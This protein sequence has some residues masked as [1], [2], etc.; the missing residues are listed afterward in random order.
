ML[1]LVASLLDSRHLKDRT[2]TRDL[3]MELVNKFLIEVFML[4]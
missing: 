3:A 2:R 1:T 4:I